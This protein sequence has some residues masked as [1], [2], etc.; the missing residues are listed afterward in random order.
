VVVQVLDHIDDMPAETATAFGFQAN[1][2][3]GFNLR[4]SF[5]FRSDMA[6][7]RPNTLDNKQS[8][9]LEEQVRTTTP[10]HACRCRVQH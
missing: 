2:A 1:A 7:L 6:A 5:R 3:T 4:Q 8:K 9:G 10:M